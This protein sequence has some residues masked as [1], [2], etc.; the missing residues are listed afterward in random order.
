MYAGRIAEEGNTDAVFERP[1]HPDTRGLMAAVPSPTH[2]RG[3]LAAI[4]GT[5]P[6]LIDPSPACRFHSRCPFAAEICR[7]L[8]PVL[9]P[10]EGHRV[11]CF[12]YEEATSYGVDPES[13]PVVTPVRR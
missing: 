2:S 1:L 6:E 5:V 7:R 3:R 12:G 4:E 9:R 8:D 11:A 13:M 10:E